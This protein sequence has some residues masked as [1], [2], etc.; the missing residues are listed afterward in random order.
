MS[1]REI[2][3]NSSRLEK[4]AAALP[5]TQIGMNS[6]RRMGSTSYPGAVLPQQ[7]QCGLDPRRGRTSTSMV[8]VATISRTA[9]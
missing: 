1:M 8:L 2:V 5:L 6:K 4:N 9:A 7:E 3:E